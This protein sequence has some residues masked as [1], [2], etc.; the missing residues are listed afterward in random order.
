M[1]WLT[2][3][4]FL[5]FLSL[6]VSSQTQLQLI[7]NTDVPVD[8]VYVV[9]W[10]DKEVAHLPFKDTLTIKFKT[11]GIDF[12]HLNYTSNGKV[13]YTPLMLDT[14]HITIIS[15]LDDKKII[16]DSV[17]GSPFYKKYVQ[18]R[19]D[20]NTLK[21]NKDSVALDAFLLRTYEDNIDN[22]FSFIIGNRYLD[23][24]QNNKL[25]L[26][27]LLPLIAKQAAGVKE[28]FG[29]SFLNERLQG[30]LKNDTVRFVDYPLIDINNKTAVMQAFKAK[31]VILDFWFV[32]CLPCFEDH[33]KLTSLFPVLKQKQT[34]FISISNDDVYE[35]W[36]DYLD[37]YKFKWQHYKKIAGS[38]NVIEQLGISTYPTYILLDEKGKILYSSVSLEEVLGQLK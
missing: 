11:R 13:Y 15:H 3:F 8:S 7:L 23:I 34:E 18:W 22:L 29:Y 36:K 17:E 16:V 20:F 4:V 21:L 2:A 19:S 25:K 5:L 1:K 33:K 24:H 26:Y 27:A 9:R 32:G 30:I 10:T 14:G 37:K 38:S 6:P 31:Y 12:Y 28:Y 35:K